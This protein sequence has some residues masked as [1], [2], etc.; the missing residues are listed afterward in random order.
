MKLNSAKCGIDK[1]ISDNKDM[2]KTVLR[3]TRN[4]NKDNIWVNFNRYHQETS[5]ILAS[6]FLNNVG[7]LKTRLNNFV[8]TSL[9][10]LNEVIL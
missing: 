5:T 2:L 4:D 6:S 7:D 9:E 10:C 1:Y 8:D 3:G